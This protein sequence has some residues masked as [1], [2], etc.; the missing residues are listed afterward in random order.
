MPFVAGETIVKGVPLAHNQ[1]GDG[2]PLLWLHSAY[3]VRLSEGLELLAKS[4]R[5]YAPVMPGFDGAASLEPLRSIADLADL[6]AGFI[7][8]AIKEPCDVIGHSFGGWIAAWLAVRHPDKIRRLALCAPAGFRP[9]GIGGLTGD[10]E[11]L[12]RKMFAHPERLPPEAKPPGMLQQNREQARRYTGDVATDGD[13]VPLLPKIGAETLLLFGTRD[14][15]I[16]VES[17]Q[18]LR[19]NIPHAHVIYLYD[20]AHSLD[21]DQPERFAKVVEDFFARGEAFVVNWKDR[22]AN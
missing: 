12:Q 4:H 6:A 2:P 16:P 20:A 22:A 3:G 1:Q 5:V 19:R 10:P 11:A 9:D 7:D 18:L 8:A 15:I 14:G 21:T 13:L 17:A